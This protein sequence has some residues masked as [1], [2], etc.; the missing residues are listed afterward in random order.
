VHVPFVLIRLYIHIVDKIIL[1][2]ESQEIEYRV[3]TIIIL[4]YT[5]T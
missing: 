4:E 1:V 3:Y 5:D 2:Q